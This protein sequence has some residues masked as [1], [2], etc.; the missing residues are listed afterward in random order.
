MRVARPAP[1]SVR[2][3]VAESSAPGR[4]EGGSHA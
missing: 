3:T 4:V 1:G 2:N